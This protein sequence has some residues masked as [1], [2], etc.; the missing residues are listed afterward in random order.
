MRGCWTI[1]SVLVVLVAVFL[2]R[3][4]KI[5]D[6]IF[7]WF[8]VQTM[9]QY[10]SPG[11]LDAIEKLAL[12][13]NS[14]LLELCIGPGYG[15][16]EALR[17]KGVKVIGVDVSPDMVKM[18]SEAVQGAIDEGRAS[19]VLGDARNLTFLGDEQVDKVFHMNCCYFWDNVEDTLKEI[20]RVMK[21]GGVMLSGVKF[22]QLQQWDAHPAFFK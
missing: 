8:A 14:T 7:G 19:V 11:V 10:N 15:V 4:Y 1:S 12:K 6:S 5:H 17:Y 22:E 21:P 3:I 20:L 2:P 9:V 18:A 16:Q 13:E